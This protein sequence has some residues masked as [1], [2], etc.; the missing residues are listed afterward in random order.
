MNY[1]A[2][3]LTHV[4]NE[5]VSVYPDTIGPKMEQLNTVLE[6]G[7]AEL[8]INMVLHSGTHIDAPSHIINNG[9]TIDRF[10][11]N[12]FYGKALRISCLDIEEI[13]LAFLLT[14][15]EQ[16]RQV[17]FIL[18]YTGWQDKWQKDGYIEDC[19][20]LTEEAAIWLTEFKLDGVGL[21]A[22][23]VD[24]VVDAEM[25]TALSLPNHH[26]LLG[27]EIPLIENLTNMDKLPDDIFDFQCF[28]LKV[29]Q[30]DGSPIRAVAFL[31]S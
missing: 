15:E 16:I 9:R 3:D 30:G 18:F 31:K 4:L 7:Y 26:I 8:Q 10:P 19:P 6:H 24:K 14:F 25:I 2:I 20:V 1:K 28:P 22:F 21:D 27:N 17:N 29:E 5:E 11:L 23:S 13:D 12:K